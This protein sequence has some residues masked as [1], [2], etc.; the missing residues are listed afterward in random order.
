DQFMKGNG[1]IQIYLDTL[2]LPD[3]T[4]IPIRAGL[5]PHGAVRGV[6]SL[7]PVEID[8]SGSI[9]LNYHTIHYTGVTVG[10][11]ATSIAA[12]SLGFFIG[13]AIS[14]GTALIDPGYAY[15]KPLH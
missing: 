2:T 5:A 12:R 13:P 8:R 9:S 11:T 6:P 15:G 7:D 10:V 4:S 14:G 3:G 1:G